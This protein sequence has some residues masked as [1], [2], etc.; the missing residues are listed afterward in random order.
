MARDFGETAVIAN[1]SG[2]LVL[3]VMPRSALV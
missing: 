3:E 2:R 1:L